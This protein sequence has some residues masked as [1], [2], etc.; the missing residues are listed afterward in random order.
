MAN[1]KTP[2]K[3]LYV[4]LP[5][6][7]ESFTIP[8]L[9]RFAIDKL[10]TEVDGRPVFIGELVVLDSHANEVSFIQKDWME[11]VEPNI[12]Y[13]IKANYRP[14]VRI[15]YFPL[16]ENNFAMRQDSI[17]YREEFQA[18]P[19]TKEYIFIPEIDRASPIRMLEYR[20]LQGDQ[21]DDSIQ[22]IE[23][24]ADFL[25]SQ[26]IEQ[27]LDLVY[28]NFMDNDALDHPFVRVYFKSE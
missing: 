25:E 10:K 8:K 7:S 14:S 21:Q 18:A 28:H 20:L 1:E 2:M 13:P 22:L 24:L 3:S 12:E 27:V 4:T 26:N 9:L 5:N 23:R 6:E 19:L 17:E 16:D 11:V 15:D